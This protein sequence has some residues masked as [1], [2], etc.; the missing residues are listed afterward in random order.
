MRVNVTVP[1]TPSVCMRRAATD[2]S[3]HSS[4]AR[5]VANALDVPSSTVLP[6]D[7]EA[8]ATTGADAFPNA[9]APTGC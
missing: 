5:A 6:S 8:P 2:F 7:V 9:A 3:Y 1:R 4:A